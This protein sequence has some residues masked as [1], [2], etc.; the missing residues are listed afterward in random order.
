VPGKAVGREL[1]AN[2]ERSVGK[3]L[4]MN[5][6]EV[7]ARSLTDPAAFGAL[8]DRYAAMLFRFFVRRVDP[9]V[10]DGLLGEVFRIAFERRSTFDGSR[11]TARPWLYGI[12]TNVLAKHHRSEARRL[13]ATAELAAR[14]ALQDDPAER[15]AAVVDARELWPRLAEAIANLPG[16]ERD[17]LLLFA[18]EELSYEEIALALGVPVGTVRSRL[19]RGRGR[20]RELAPSSGEEPSTVSSAARQEDC[21]R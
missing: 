19:N 2:R 10:A 15:V 6:S 21:D 12:A 14:R 8:F 5:D 9:S 17:A 13:R 4:E 18:W 7:I 1:S 3:E 11:I 16:A 20:L